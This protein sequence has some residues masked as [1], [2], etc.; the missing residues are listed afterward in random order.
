MGEHHLHPGP[1]LDAAEQTQQEK[2]DQHSG[3]GEP[4]YRYPGLPKHSV[5]L[6]QCKVLKLTGDKSV[7]IFIG[8]SP[9]VNRI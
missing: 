3:F 4:K 6:T 9:S 1:G 8:L 7:Y 5:H 2:G